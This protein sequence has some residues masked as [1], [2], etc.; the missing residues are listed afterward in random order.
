[1]V[2]ETEGWKELIEPETKNRFFMDIR[3]GRLQRSVPE[4]VFEYRKRRLVW[5]ERL[6][7][8]R[9]VERNGDWELY[10]LNQ[11]DR[12]FFL[13]SKTKECVW[14]RPQEVTGWRTRKVEDD[15]LDEEELKTMQA[16]DHI[17]DLIIPDNFDPNRVFKGAIETAAMITTNNSPL[18]TSR[19]LGEVSQSLLRHHC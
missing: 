14:R 10:R 3:S 2:Q 9:L 16:Q 7:R 6:S 18:T 17:N 19:I 11:S 13:H 12:Y 15:Y 8:A 4:K 5:K 1:V